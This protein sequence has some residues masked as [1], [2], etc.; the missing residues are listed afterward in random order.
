[1][2]LSIVFKYRGI[3][4]FDPRKLHYR[5]KYFFEAYILRPTF[6]EFIRF[7]IDEYKSKKKLDEH[8][9]PAYRFCSLCQVKS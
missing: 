1:M 8:W 7:V 6:T 9:E 4:K 2:A 3:L 5:R